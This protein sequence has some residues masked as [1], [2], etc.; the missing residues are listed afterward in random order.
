IVAAE[1]FYAWK[2]RPS[3]VA[4]F[5]VTILR[6]ESPLSSAR[7]SV[8]RRAFFC[9]LLLG[10]NHLHAADAGQSY[11]AEVERWRKDHANNLFSDLRLMIVSRFE[12][13]EG[14]Y[15]LGAGKS[16]NLVLPKGPPFLG[17]IE[18]HGKSIEIGLQPGVSGTLNNKPITNGVVLLL[19]N[20]Q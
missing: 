17:T 18:V 2:K 4:A 16:N 5:I 9:L 8:M 13:H 7:I 3:T 11:R 10:C 12:L 1:D 20:T 14:Q 15:T 6:S 19:Q